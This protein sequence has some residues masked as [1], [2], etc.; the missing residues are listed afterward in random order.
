[1]P[2]RL[3]P[4]LLVVVFINICA[5][6][7]LAAGPA[8]PAMLKLEVE[9]A[10]PEAQQ[11]DLFAGTSNRTRLTL[12]VQ[13]PDTTMID[14]DE[15]ASKLTQFVD[16]KGTDL[17]KGDERFGMMNPIRG[18]HVADDGHRATVDIEGGVCPVNGATTITAKGTLAIKCGADPKDEKLE[19]IALAKGTK[20]TIAGV[21][22]TISEVNSSSNTQIT[23][24]SSKP[25]D[26]VRE[27]KFL[28]P[29]GKEIK[30]RYSGGSSMKF[31]ST[32]TYQKMYELETKAS[33]VTI[34]VSYWG[35]SQTVS[36]PL[37]MKAGVGF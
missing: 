7:A 32:A 37:E 19:K 5:L 15:E 13:M 36:V 12:F 1:M 20:L 30:S 2:S 10:L 8:T 29:A 35:K 22:V 6:P 25:L 9:H 27:L 26:A 18:M 4:V 21:P 17:S 3:S 33:S 11:K 23:F 34:A 31:G 24:E 28:D 16:D 14:L